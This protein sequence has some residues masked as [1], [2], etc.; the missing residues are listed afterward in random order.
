VDSSATLDKLLNVSPDQPASIHSLLTGKRQAVID[1]LAIENQAIAAKAQTWKQFKDADISSTD[2]AKVLNYL[3]ATSSSG[4]KF[5][6]EFV[7]AL[8]ASG[9]CAAA[10]LGNSGGF[11]THSNNDLRTANATNTLFDE[12]NHLWSELERHGIADKTTLVIGSEFGRT[13]WYNNNA[14][15]DHWSTGSVILMSKG[16]PGNRVIGSSNDALKPNKINPVTLERDNI[17]GIEMNVQHIHRALR[18]HMG[19]QG[20]PLNAKYPLL[21]ES[22]N[23]FT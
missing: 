23:L 15:K 11:D 20:T 3:P 8:L 7:A 4:V 5:Q 17:N 16:I 12:I 13:P 18:D 14:G 1:Q 19:F 10:A 6:A 22:L 2:I 9:Q 21:A